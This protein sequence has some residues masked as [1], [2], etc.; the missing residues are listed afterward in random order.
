MDLLLFGLP[1]F[2]LGGMNNGGTTCEGKEE[3]MTR[4][5]WWGK[6]RHS[7]ATDGDSVATWVEPSED[8][9]V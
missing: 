3:K 9:S 2:Q 6:V 8:D 4:R 5:A 7:S 1:Q